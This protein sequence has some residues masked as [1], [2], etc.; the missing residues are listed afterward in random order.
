LQS[1]DFQ[2]DVNVVYSAEQNSFLLAYL[3]FALLTIC[4][5][6]ARYEWSVPVLSIADQVPADLS[7]FC[8]VDNLLTFIQVCRAEQTRFQLTYLFFALLTIC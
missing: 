5:L 1:V 4:C 2:L 7:V 6:A 3:F 8:S